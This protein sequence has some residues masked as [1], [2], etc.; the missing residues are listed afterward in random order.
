MTACTGAPCDFARDH[1]IAQAPLM[2][3]IEH[4][5]RG[6][7]YGA[8]SWATREQVQQSALR[9]GLRPGL[10]LLDIGAGSGWPALFLAR[11]S[12]CEVVLSDLPLS[13]LRIARARAVQDGLSSRCSVL[14]AN[15]AALPFP[16]GKF[17]FIHH[18]DVLCCTD[19][20]REMLDECRRVARPG[21]RMEFSVISLAR[22]P[23]DE[24]ELSLL[25]QSG[26]P[27]P[28]A[29]GD[30]ADLLRKAGWDVL[31]RIDVTAEFARCMDILLEEQRERRD[32]LLELLG[33]QD[34]AERVVRRRS[35]RVALSR[36]LLRREIFVSA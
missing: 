1:E 23:S 33:E 12:G 31:E 15:G 22:K 21:A 29:E 4:R 10:R 16:G 6:S 25:Q 34:Y 26:P 18:A 20:K 35:T 5:V 28:D 9:L 13:G 19:R 27:Y 36:G 32:A 17:D 11:L 2:R 7:D 3:E 24:R 14:A 30:Y 8:T